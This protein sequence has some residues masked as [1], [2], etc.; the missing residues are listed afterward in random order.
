MK[1]QASRRSEAIEVVPSDRGFDELV[2]A[3]VTASRALVGVSARSLADVEETVTLTQFR[4]LVVLRTHGVSR[5]NRLSDRLQVNA[6]TTLRTV[7]RLIAAG[8]VD[9]RDNPRDRREVI[10]E[11]TDAG[12][13]LVDVVTARRRRAIEGIVLAMPAEQR[14]AMIEALLAFADAADEPIA[15][16]DSATRMGW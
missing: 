16:S 11:L 5:L 10:I 12:R 15:V 2:T 13:R 1:D 6:S 14:I 4:N 7:E 9:R 8:L 3:L